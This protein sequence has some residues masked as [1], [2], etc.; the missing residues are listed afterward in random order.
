MA[1]ALLKGSD[2]LRP[3]A[4]SGAALSFASELQHL[5][6]ATLFFLA[7]ATNTEYLLVMSNKPLADLIWCNKKYARGE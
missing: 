7:T 5:G 3:T 6:N 4:P 1:P 2:M